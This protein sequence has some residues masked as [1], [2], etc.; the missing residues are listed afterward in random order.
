MIGRKELNR[1]FAKMG[2]STSKLSRPSF[3]KLFRFADNTFESLGQITILLSTPFGI[4]RIYVKFD[5][6]QADVPALIGM[7]IPDRDSPIADTLAKRLTNRVR[8]EHKD[9]TTSYIDEWSVPLYRAL[10]NHV[11]ARTKLA[12]KVY[13]RRAKVLKLHQKLFHP[14]GRKLFNLLLRARPEEAT[15]GTLES[16]QDLAKRC[17]PCRRICKAPTR[18]RVSFGGKRSASIRECSLISCALMTDLYCILL[19]KVP[20]FQQHSSSPTSQRRYFGRRYSSF[21]RK[22]TQDHQIVCSST[23]EGHLVHFSSIFVLYQT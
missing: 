20:T 12:S 7:D 16:S 11:I 21:G 9:G 19:M 18:L 22:F 5:F 17:D 2:M 23:K 13:F 1:I 3:S 15:P 8:E 4:A 10:S 6:V 14:S